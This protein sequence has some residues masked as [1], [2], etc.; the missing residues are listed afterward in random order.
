MKLLRICIE[1]S[2]ITEF[3][4]MHYKGGA[5]CPNCRGCTRHH[6]PGRKRNIIRLGGDK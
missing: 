6:Q 4:H 3:N 5:L 2:T 1:C